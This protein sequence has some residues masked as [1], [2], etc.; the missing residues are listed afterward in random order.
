MS[1]MK[2]KGT[3]LLIDNIERSY[4]HDDIV[5]IMSGDAIP[6]NDRYVLL[7]K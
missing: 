7:I 1:N 4:N 2:L 3:K 5:E 6:D